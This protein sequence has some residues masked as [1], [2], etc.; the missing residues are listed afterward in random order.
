[1]RG[2]SILQPYAIF[3]PAAPYPDR[4][5]I[6][7][8]L[9]GNIAYIRS[10]DYLPPAR[11]FWSIAEHNVEFKDN[12]AY[13]EPGFHS[14]RRTFQFLSRPDVEGRTAF[15]LS[16]VGGSGAVFASDVVTNNIEEGEKASGISSIFNGDKGANICYRYVDGTLSDEPLW[17]WPM[18]KR[19]HDAM[20]E[21]GRSPVDVTKTIEE[22]FGPIPKIC[23]SDS[24]ADLI[25]P[26]APA[27]VQIASE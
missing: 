13:I 24:E 5:K 1:M 8:K 2:E 11:L 9:L 14:D 10:S 23:R 20:I 4:P 12:V 26:L 19:I 21:S 25:P 18:D 3:T 27:N 16:G 6:N 7:G 22:M 17:P 15:D